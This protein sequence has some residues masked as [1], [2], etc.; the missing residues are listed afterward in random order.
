MTPFLNFGMT[1]SQTVSIIS[2]TMTELVMDVDVKT[3]LTLSMIANV[4]EKE[5]KGPKPII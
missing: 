1:T 5:I 2:I 4:E 3:L